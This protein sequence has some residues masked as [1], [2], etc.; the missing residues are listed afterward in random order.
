[1]SVTMP[2]RKWLPA[3]SRIRRCSSWSA[4]CG[5]S[6]ADRLDEPNFVFGRT[7]IDDAGRQPE[8]EADR[9]RCDVANHAGLAGAKAIE[10]PLP[11]QAIG[12]TVEVFSRDPHLDEALLKV[13]GMSA[14][15]AVTERLAVLAPLQP[16]LDD[17]AHELRLING[18][19][20]LG[21]VKI[22]G[23]GLTPARSG[24]LGAK[25]TKGDR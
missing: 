9:E 25:A 21:F 2:R 4:P 7:S 1:M 11:V 22:A 14:I 17:I 15:D 8:I 20:Y 5:E 3:W 19:C 18:V 6:A 23:D 12:E 16:G 13:L 24:S 10:D